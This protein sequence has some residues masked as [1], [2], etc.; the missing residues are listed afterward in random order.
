[1]TPKKKPPVSGAALK[2]IPEA[3]STRKAQCYILLQILHKKGYSTPF[4]GEDVT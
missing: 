2:R 4:V 1:M 3:D